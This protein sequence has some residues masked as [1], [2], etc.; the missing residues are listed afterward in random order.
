MIDKLLFLVPSAKSRL[1][2]S[3]RKTDLAQTTFW[4]K[5]CHPCQYHYLG[6]TFKPKINA[7]LQK[8]KTYWV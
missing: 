3:S 4:Q 1:E 2:A 8:T 5:K 7:I 6:M